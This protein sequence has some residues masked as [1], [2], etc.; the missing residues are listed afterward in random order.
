MV[1]VQVQVQEKEEDQDKEEDK[2]KEKEKDFFKRY[3]AQRFT[4][5]FSESWHW[6]LIMKGFIR[7]V[8]ARE[9]AE[10]PENVGKAVGRSRGNGGNKDPGRTHGRYNKILII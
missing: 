6:Q 5:E 3:N 7:H 2:D 10:Y 8:F 9:T 1:Q 4:H